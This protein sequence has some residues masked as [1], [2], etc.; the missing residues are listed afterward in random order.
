DGWSLQILWREICALYD[1][2]KRGDANPLPAVEIQY[3]DYAQWERS[4]L[5]GG[6]LETH[7]AYWKRQLAGVAGLELPRDHTLPPVPSF[8]GAAHAFALAPELGAALRVLSSDTAC[9]LFMTMFSVFHVLLS[10]LSGQRD[11]AVVTPI[12]GRSHRGTEA[13]VGTCVNSL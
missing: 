13:L 5:Q 9:S 8:E 6:A 4:W 10:R 7:M 12:A 1:G 11:F 2:F 3:A